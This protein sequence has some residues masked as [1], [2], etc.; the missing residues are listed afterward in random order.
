MGS[1][2]S[3]LY[4]YCHSLLLAPRAATKYWHGLVAS[5]AKDFSPFGVVFAIADEEDYSDELR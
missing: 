4:C 3:L 5:I 1:K 2:V